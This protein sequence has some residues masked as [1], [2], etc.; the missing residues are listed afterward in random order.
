V[1]DY[2]GPLIAMIEKIVAEGFTAPVYADMLVVES[3]IETLLQRFASY[4]APPRKWLLSQ[5][6]P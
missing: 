6:K 3:G 5:P 2:F 1:K 4:Q